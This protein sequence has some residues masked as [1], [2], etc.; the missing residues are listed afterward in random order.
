MDANSSPNWVDSQLNALN[1]TANW[2]PGITAA[3]A[4]LKNHR[5]SRFLPAPKWTRAIAATVCLALGFL[6]FPSPRALAHRCLDC[7]LA[8]LHT[9]SPYRIS[10]V[11]PAAVSPLIPPSSRKPAPAFSLPDA[12]GH[13]LS[14]SSLHG[15]VVLL[16]FWA[17][18]C[19]GCQIE[20]PW[21]IEFQKKY[22]E[23]DVTIIGIAMDDDGWSVVKSWIREKGVNY[24]IVIGNAQ[25]GSEYGLLGMP[26]TVLIDREGRIADVRSGMIKKL[27]TEKQI[28]SLLTEPSDQSN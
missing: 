2:D 10:R 24:P 15:H 28:A 3:F 7:S 8:I 11:S 13:P 25:L 12:S 26:L 1:P 6:A 9:L 5:Q 27:A 21:F 4:E 17:T 19:H 23:K 16:N 14:L 22:A 20:I 18:W